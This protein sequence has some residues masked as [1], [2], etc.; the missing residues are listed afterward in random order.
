MGLLPRDSEQS[1]PVHPTQLYEVL[2]GAGLV[3]LL[4]GARKRQTFRGQIFLLFVF[5]YG[6]GRFLLELLRDDSERGSIPPALPEHVL[7]PLGAAVLATGYIVG[8]SKAIESPGVRRATSVLAFVPAVLLYLAL[9]PMWRSD[10]TAP[11]ARGR[12]QP[13]CIGQ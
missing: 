4:L 12:A 8:F 9:K 2:L 1:L 6:V 11:Q 7:I 5:V 3:A 13:V 10:R